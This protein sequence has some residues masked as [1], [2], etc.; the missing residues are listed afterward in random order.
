MGEAN[1][2]IGIEIFHNRSHELLGLPQ[3]AYINKVLD[4]GSSGLRIIK[5]GVE[6]IINVS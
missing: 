6:L 4:A 5:K 2:V 3:K 1:Y